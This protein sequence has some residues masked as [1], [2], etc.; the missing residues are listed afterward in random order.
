MLPGEKPM[1]RRIGFAGN[2]PGA[3]W[4]NA[5]PGTE[6]AATTTQARKRQEPVAGTEAAGG[7]D[8]YRVFERVRMHLLLHLASGAPMAD[9]VGRRPPIAFRNE[10]F[11]LQQAKRRGK[12]ARAT[13]DALED[14][15][16]FCPRPSTEV[17]R[18]EAIR[19]R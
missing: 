6:Q 15:P 1:T 8:R 2:A 7:R 10:G 19:C 9:P 3:A 5:A 18:I 17:H 4:A 16:H 14:M 13:P 12:A 11:R